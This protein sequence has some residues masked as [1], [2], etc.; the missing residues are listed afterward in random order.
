MTAVNLFKTLPVFFVL[1]EVASN[2]IK[3]AEMFLQ[4]SW[5]H[6]PGSSSSEEK[7]DNCSKFLS[8]LS[9]FSD[10][11]TPPLSIADGTGV[12]GDVFP[13]GGGYKLLWS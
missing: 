2:A 12:A 13:S 3:G 5:P 11:L 6:M 7:E 1:S 9:T 4:A 10:G 8:S